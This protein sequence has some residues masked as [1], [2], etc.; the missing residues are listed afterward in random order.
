MNATTSN[1]PPFA[2]PRY[3]SPVFLRYSGDARNAAEVQDGVGVLERIRDIALRHID[4]SESDVGNAITR[5]REELALLEAAGVEAQ[6]AG[7]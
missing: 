5:I 2:F 1:R 6:K 4:H 7:R 3:T